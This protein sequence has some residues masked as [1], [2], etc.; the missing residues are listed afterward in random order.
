MRTKVVYIISNIDKALE[1]EWVAEYLNQE[2][3]ELSFILLNPMAN[4]HLARFVES[5]GLGLKYIPYSGKKDLVFAFYKLYKYLKSLQPDVIHCHLP[6]ATLLGLSIGKI[7]GIKERIYTRH[8][9]TFN[10]DYHPHAVK[11]DLWSNQ[12]AT[13]IIAI[14]QNVADVLIEKEGV[15]SDKIQIINHSIDIDRF[16]SVNSERV[17]TLKQ[18][19]GIRSE[20][21]IIGVISRY[22]EW[23]GIQYIIPAFKRI[24]EQYPKAQLVLANARKGEYVD[25]LDILLAE[26]PQESYIEIPFEKDLYAL[27]QLFDVF[28]HT[29][30]DPYCEAFGQIYIE[31]LAAKIPSVFT[32][33]GVARDFVQHEKEALVV[34]F[35]STEQIHEAILRLLKDPELSEVLKENGFEVVDQNYRIENKIDQLSKA[36]DGN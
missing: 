19:Y 32:L 35:K 23:K 17:E 30:I 34:D 22:T 14:T 36:F 16:T 5:Q 6:E 29:P 15:S 27:Y 8:H 24:L 13:K 21:P 10:H 25:Q 28:V 26:L 9:S 12:W 4:S 20:G 2:R 11:Y 31:S 1:F 7:L 18:K 33:S 3:F